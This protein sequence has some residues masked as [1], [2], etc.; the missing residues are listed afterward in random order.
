MKINK[1]LI[2]LSAQSEVK[3]SKYLVEV[4][5]DLAK[6]SVPDNFTSLSIDCS[7]TYIIKCGIET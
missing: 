2:Y 5:I 3:L 6:F 1:L 7:V 4:P